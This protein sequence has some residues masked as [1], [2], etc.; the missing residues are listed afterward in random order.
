MSLIPLA[1]Y[2]Y[3]LG[4]AA[5]LIAVSWSIKGLIGRQLGFYFNIAAV[6][7]IVSGCAYAMHRELSECLLSDAP[8]FQRCE[9][10]AA[11]FWLVIAMTITI[12]VPLIVSAIALRWRSKHSVTHPA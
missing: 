5:A 7:I 10:S 9:C 12:L 8:S 6:L 4:V 2:G 1:Y 3:A 11:V